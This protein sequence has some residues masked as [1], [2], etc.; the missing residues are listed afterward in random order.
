MLSLVCG[1]SIFQSEGLHKQLGSILRKCVSVAP[2]TPTNKLHGMQA[3]LAT[4]DE[5]TSTIDMHTVVVCGTH[6]NSSLI[7]HAHGVHMPCNDPVL[8][9]R[10]HLTTL[11]QRKVV[12]NCLTGWE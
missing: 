9:G 12:A 10:Q 8:G 1:G 6:C 3:A 5:E 7:N 11:P 4:V 2:D